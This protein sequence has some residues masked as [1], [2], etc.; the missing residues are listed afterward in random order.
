MDLELN[1]GTI[2]FQRRSCFKKCPQVV[3]AHGNLL[4]FVAVQLFRPL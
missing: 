4:L 1:V 2:H 3:W